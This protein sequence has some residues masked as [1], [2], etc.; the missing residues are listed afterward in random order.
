[1]LI[2]YAIIAPTVYAVFAA[3]LRKTQLA[4]NLLRSG[5]PARLLTVPHC[6]VVP[7]RKPKRSSSGKLSWA[8]AGGSRGERES[9]GNGSLLP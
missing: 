8:E 5:N 9:E 1:M 4:M 6:M 3:P 2:S 7:R